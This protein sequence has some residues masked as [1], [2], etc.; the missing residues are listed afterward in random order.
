[1]VSV[2]EKKARKKRGES[3]AALV[4]HPLRAQIWVALINQVRSPV[5]LERLLG[6][7]LSDISYHVK[8]L[9]K[10]GKIEVV[11]TEPVRGALKHFYTATERLVVTDDEY[12][13]MSLTDRAA[14]DRETLQL[15]M[16]DAIAS[17]ESGTFCERTDHA[18]IRLMGQVDEEGFKEARDL[19]EETLTRLHEIQGRSANRRGEEP[20]RPAIPITS[21]LLMFERPPEIA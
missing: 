4:A 14:I 1:M 19:M 11:R 5:E 6:A 9:H 20:G 10:K 13:A 7:D 16:A 17:L 12:E 8:E 18:N 2:K 3:L 21:V 15:A